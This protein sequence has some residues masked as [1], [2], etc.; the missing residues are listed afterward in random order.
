MPAKKCDTWLEGSK[1]SRFL[2]GFVC[3]K[4]AQVDKFNINK[5]TQTVTQ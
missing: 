1:K 4:V 5:I 3:S 2:A